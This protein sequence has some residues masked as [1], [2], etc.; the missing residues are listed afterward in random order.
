MTKPNF[1]KMPLHWDKLMTDP[2]VESMSDAG[3][4]SY[5]KL[6]WKAWF[7][8]TPGTLP[9]DDRMLAAWAGRTAR[10]WAKLKEQV[11]APWTLSEGVWTQRRMVEVYQDSLE[12]YEKKARAGKDS[13]KSR[14]GVPR[15]TPERSSTPPATHGASL[16]H[17][18]RN[19]GATK[20]L[21]LPPDAPS[22]AK[23]GGGATAPLPPTLEAAQA[24]FKEKYPDK[25]TPDQV[26]SA[27]NSLD[28]TKNTASGKWYIGSRPVADWR[29]GMISR[30]DLIGPKFVPF[31]GAQGR[32][33]ISRPNFEDREAI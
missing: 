17:S 3:F 30:M 18:S 29:T 4:R 25:Y 13:W 20:D 11:M 32:G 6:L 19:A 7:Y 8:A 23:E 2:K 21:V 31:P 26:E 12:S 27:W 28:A 10:E 15:E 22:G 9:N 14:K 33:P 1:F 16:E 5:L 24:Y